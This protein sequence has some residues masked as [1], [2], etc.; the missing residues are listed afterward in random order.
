M[1]DMTTVRMSRVA[2]VVLLFAGAAILV[3]GGNFTTRRDVLEVGG[4]TVVAEEQRPIAPW[5]AVAVLVSG[6][7]LMVVSL[8]PRTD[9]R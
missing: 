9:S 1:R 5:V 2:G 4:L 7:A 3:W 6:L 8:R